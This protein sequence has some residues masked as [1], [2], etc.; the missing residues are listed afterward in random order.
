MPR[1]RNGC[2]RRR[3]PILPVC[4]CDVNAIDDVDIASCSF[5]S[6]C[7]TPRLFEIF[8]RHI[9]SKYPSGDIKTLSEFRESGGRFFPSVM[10]IPVHCPRRNLMALAEITGLRGG[11]QPQVAFYVPA[12][13]SYVSPRRA[14]KILLRDVRR[15][16]QD[17]L[18][19]GHLT[20]RSAGDTVSKLKRA[21]FRLLRLPISK[22]VEASFFALKRIQHL[23][24]GV[25]VVGR[26]AFSKYEARRLR[27][28]LV[29]SLFESLIT[30]VS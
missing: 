13:G 22:D 30:L 7:L 10:V 20:S 28:F 6:K 3:S 17:L 16:Y 29:C 23:A 5:P 1:K 12:I 8:A 15:V 19:Q 11:L 18:M 27:R 2:R 4:N 26:A 14:K 9:L 25:D 24:S 21:E